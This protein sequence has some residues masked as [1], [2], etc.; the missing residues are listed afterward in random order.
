MNWTTEQWQSSLR[1][2]DPIER[3]NAT[4]QLQSRVRKAIFAQFLEKGLTGHC[5]EDV[6]QETTRRIFR[7]L[8]TFRGE[9]SFLTWATAFAVRTGLEMLRRGFWS[10]RT[11]SDFYMDDDQVD[12]ASLWQSHMPGPQIVAQQSEVLNLLTNAINSQLTTRQRC[13]L[14][15]ELQGWTVSRVAAELGTTPGAVYKLTHDARRKLKSVLA[16]AGL[17]GDAVR[18]L[19]SL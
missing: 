7:Q 5:V 4:L 2:V 13:A 14:I 12:L 17:D 18:E 3:D 19:F 11:S 1:S 6:V 9:S 15:R 8:D 10:A 16:E